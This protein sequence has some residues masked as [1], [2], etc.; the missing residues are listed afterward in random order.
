M[1]HHL[2]HILTSVLLIA[3]LLAPG[4]AVAQEGAREAQGYFEKGA[5]LY[6]EG[7]YGQALVQFKKGHA[8]LPNAMFQYN[9][10]L[11]NLKLE[12][13]G[14]AMTAAREA[15]RLGGLASR[16]AAM[17]RSR[18]IAI[19]RI[20]RTQAVA[21]DVSQ[22]QAAVVEVTA[23]TTTEETGS[24]EA[25]PE[26]SSFGAL[27]WT[28]VGLTAVGAGLLV[29]AVGVEVG[30]QGTWDEYN[31]A[32]EEGDTERFNELKTEIESRQSTGKAL[33]YAGIGAGAVGVALIVAELVTS[34]RSDQ[35]R[36]SVFASP[37]GSAGVSAHFRF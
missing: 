6:F 4:S 2:L 19:P 5:A 37:D 14:E 10:A 25:K 15:E 35:P 7:E 23:E 31:A 13:Y 30:L 28:G 24:I 33:L 1:T 8:T 3:A 17:N 32:A 12:R 27:G 26:R 18:I 16:E 9:I 22:A 21:E 20:E 34:P 11:C 29:G 36:V